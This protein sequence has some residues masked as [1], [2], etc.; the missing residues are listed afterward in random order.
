[1]KIAVFHG[2]PRKGNT[3]KATGFF[4]D[5]LSKRQGV[6][7]TEFFLPEAL[8]EFCVG[9]QLCLG[10]PHDKCPHFQY[11]LPIYDAIMAADALVFTTPHYGACSM[12]GGMKN[13][14]DHLDFL[15]L[16]VSPRKEIFR[17]K[18]FIITTGAGAVSAGKP[19]RKYLKNWG[20][21]RVYLFGIRM[22]VNE[23]HGMPQ[24]KQDEFE[25]KLRRKANRF[26]NVKKGWPYL[27]AIFMYYMSAFI[28]KKFI[29]ADAY[30][31]KYWQEN[32]YFTKRP[33]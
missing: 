13:L 23:W 6:E 21:N 1:M 10:N 31:Y 3:Y 12:S 2:S 20:V 5:E 32:G 11:V 8:P 27:S 29:G 14:L 7:F 28:L 26:Y 19:I 15:T 4:M 18:A 30:P 33:F 17:K 9:C 25:K 16:A 24:K 22:L